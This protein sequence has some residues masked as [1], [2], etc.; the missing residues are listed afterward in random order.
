MSKGQVHMNDINNSYKQLAERLDTLPN[1]FPPTDDGSELRLLAKLFTPE[2]ADLASQLKIKLE[3]AAQIADR[4]GIRYD[5]TRQML[6]SMARHG[7]IRA[8]KIDNELGYGLLPFAVGIYENQL[9]MMDEELAR[10]F[11]NYYLS[12][13]EKMLAVQPAIH[14]VVPVGES[15][16]MDMQVAPYESAAGIIEHAQSWG[17]QDCI[18]RVQTRLIGKPC[19]H[20][21]DMCMVMSPAPDAF[22]NSPVIKS[23]TKEEAYATLRRA[24][25]AGLVHSVSNTQ[26]GDW[27]IC[28]CCTCSCAILRGMAELGIA[29]VVA[30][31]A[32]I[33]TVDLTLCNACGLCVENCQFTALT[34]DDVAIVNRTRCVGCGICVNACPDHALRL[35]RRPEEEIK[36]VPINILDWG[37]QRAQDRGIDLTPIL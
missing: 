16:R 35:V 15:I 12:S 22:A 37:I 30:S 28:N 23:L 29:N 7:L 3:S 19:K 34:V 2:E 32:F 25:E 8:G 18:C 33:N 4:L 27:Y 26:H 20:P 6:K 5:H 13:F 10:L 24:D 11:E 21:V 17:V 36:P 9:S 14:R 31:S 1:G